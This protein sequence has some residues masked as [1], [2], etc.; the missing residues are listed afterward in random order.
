M[1]VVPSN[2][3]R[4]KPLQ[5]KGYSE[6]VNNRGRTQWPT[7]SDCFQPYA[8]VLQKFVSPQ[9]SVTHSNEAWNIFNIEEQQHYEKHSEKGTMQR[10]RN[11]VGVL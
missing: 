5:G 10:L 3:N 11:D 2:E 4:W 8:G 9:I 1:S 6:S 7:L